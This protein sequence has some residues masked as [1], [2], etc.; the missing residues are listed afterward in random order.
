MQHWICGIVIAVERWP[1]KDE[2]TIGGSEA[3]RQLGL[4]IPCIIDVLKG[5]IVWHMPFNSGLECMLHTI[6]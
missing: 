1:P 5:V 2:V 6:V 3:A 4:S